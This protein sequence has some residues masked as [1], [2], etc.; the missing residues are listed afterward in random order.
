[1]F[2]NA[3]LEEYLFT[4]TAL[5]EGIGYWEE[6]TRTK[7]LIFAQEL[8]CDRPL[9]YYQMLKIAMRAHSIPN[10]VHMLLPQND[11]SWKSSFARV[12]FGEY[13][14]S[15]LQLQHGD[16]RVVEDFCQ[17]INRKKSS[18]PVFRFYST[19]KPVRISMRLTKFSSSSGRSYK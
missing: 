13:L 7:F 5:D 8:Y 14:V 12:P 3:R 6:P 17:D 18:D 19:S 10:W 2:A 4:A 15:C 9:E 11:K 16:M 1:M